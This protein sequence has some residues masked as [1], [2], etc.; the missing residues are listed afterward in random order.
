MEGRAFPRPQPNGRRNPRKLVSG[1]QGWYFFTMRT[2]PVRPGGEDR[3]RAGLRE[4]KREGAL[5]A[6]FG[7]REGAGS[8]VRRGTAEI[9]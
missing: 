9:D 2:G 6:G 4:V 1:P 7:V 5:E 8:K 3:G